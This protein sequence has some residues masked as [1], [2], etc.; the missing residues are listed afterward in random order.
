MMNTHPNDSPGL[1]AAKRHPKYNP[2]LPIG[3]QAQEVF[4]VWWSANRPGAPLPTGNNEAVKVW[5][6]QRAKGGTTK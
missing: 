2:H 1:V 3:D 6:K 5:A 4:A